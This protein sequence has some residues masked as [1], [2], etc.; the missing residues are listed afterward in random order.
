MSLFDKEPLKP[1]VVIYFSQESGEAMKALAARL[2]ADDRQP[3]ETTLV[4]SSAFADEVLKAQGIIIEKGCMNEGA[5]ERAYR[6]VLPDCEVHYVTRS[7]EWYTGEEPGEEPR[8]K[9]PGAP[10][11]ANE[12]ANVADSQAGEAAQPDVQT[13]PDATETAASADEAGGDADEVVESPSGD[14]GDIDARLSAD[15]GDAT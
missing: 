1:H 10:T 13:A 3:V 2:R 7:G 12:N 8:Q 14:A 9:V 5:I 11:P 15:S 6:D 4:W